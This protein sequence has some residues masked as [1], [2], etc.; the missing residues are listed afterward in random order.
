[1]PRLNSYK[2]ILLPACVLATFLVAAGVLLF[3]SEA[4]MLFRAQELSLFLP[5]RTFYHTLAI[6]PGGTL[7]FAACYF[8][9]FFFHPWLGVLWLTLFWWLDAWLVVQLFRLRGAWSLLGLLVPL[10]LLACLTQTGYWI[11]YQKLDGHLWVPTL[12]ITCSLLSALVYRR[13]PERWWLR[14][15]WMTVWG[16]VGYPLCG[17]YSFAGTALMM[18]PA[19]WERTK[20]QRHLLPLLWGAALI[21]LVPQAAYYCYS[22]VEQAQLYRAAMPV[23]GIG[24]E[25]FGQYRLPYYALAL[26]LAVAAV[27]S[28][29]AK[30]CNSWP[31]LSAV[32]PVLLVA[33]SC[34]GVKRVWYVDTNFHKEIRMHRAISQQ[35][36]ERVL[37]IAREQSDVPP[38]RVIVMCRNLALFRLGRAGDEACHYLEGDTRGNAPWLVRVSQVCGRL[39]YYHYGMENFCYRWCMENGVE[40]GWNTEEL[41]LMA[42][43]SILNGEPAVARKYLRLLAKTR[44]YKDWAAHYEAYLEHPEL[45]RQDSEMEPITHLLPSANRL[46]TDNATAE[47]YILDSFSTAESTDTLCQELTLFCALLVRDINLFWPRF[48]AYARLHEG[49]HIPRHYQ[50]AAYLY[51]HLEDRV[52]ISHMPFDPEVRQTYDEFMRF[53]EQCGPMSLEQRKVAFRPRFGGTFYYYYFLVRGL[54]TS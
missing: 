12:G 47:T 2:S 36:W 24:T 21:L 53:N 51:G 44:Y 25:D 34:V 33:V 8:T 40:M 22:Q 48:F 10:A 41:C 13:L 11:Y 46:D 50:E 35:D 4:D 42:K 15:A 9:Q 17:A 39:L 54:Q 1:M 6:Y 14:L 27:G 38:S 37:Q 45:I 52:D 43:A 32:V 19:E 49:Q 23:F 20:W 18:L 31:R 30:R 16:V 3:R 28:Y 29:A 5:T 7:S 26:A